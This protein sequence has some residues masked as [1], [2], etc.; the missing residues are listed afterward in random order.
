MSKNTRKNTF[1]A[2]APNY[3]EIASRLVEAHYTRVAAK[4]AVAL[5]AERGNALAEASMLGA[6]KS[7]AVEFANC[8]VELFDAHLKAPLVKAF[9]A[10]GNKMPGP[11]IATIKLAFVA[12]ANGVV[13]TK[14]VAANVQKFVNEQARGEL[15]AKGL[16]D[17]SETRGRKAGTT[18]DKVKDARR[19]AA[20]KLA[21]TG[22]VD[23]KIVKARVDALLLLTSAGNWKLL[24]KVLADACRTLNA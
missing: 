1:A 15:K 8:T 10:R 7:V 16:I 19:D 3:D 13:P 9:E 14:D 2:T 22:N 21:Q 24:E 20:I 23:A 18:S 4:E 6:I 17:A 11:I 12:I 5:E